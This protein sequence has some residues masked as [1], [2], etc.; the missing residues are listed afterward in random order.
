MRIHIKLSRKRLN[1]KRITAQKFIDSWGEK[2]RLTREEPVQ[3]FFVLKVF[4][5]LLPQRFPSGF[6]AAKAIAI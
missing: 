3:L 6:D 2:Q 1:K 4:Y 5:D